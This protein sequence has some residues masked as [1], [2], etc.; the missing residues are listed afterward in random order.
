MTLGERIREARK[1]KY[2]QE[3]L[4]HELGVHGNTLRR[5]ELGE[6]SPDAQI[7]PLLAQKLNVSV[8]DLLEGD[9][10]EGVIKKTAPIPSTRSSRWMLVYERDG[11]RMELPATDQGYEIMSKIA[12]AIANRNSSP[13]LQGAEN[14]PRAVHQ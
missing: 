8:S 7:I 11:E 10:S 12:E 2:T 14:L 3:E 1:G 4:A 13:Q 6:R 9:D 5:W